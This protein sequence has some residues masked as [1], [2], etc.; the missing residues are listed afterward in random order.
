MQMSYFYSTILFFFFHSEH[1][2]CSE[3]GI[4]SS[5]IQIT[6]WNMSFQWVRKH[7]A[8]NIPHLVNNIGMSMC[9]LHLIGYL[10]AHFSVTFDR[11]KWQIYSRRSQKQP[12]Q[13]HCKIVQE[14]RMNLNAGQQQ[15]TMLLL[16][17]QTGRWSAVNTH[18]V[19]RQQEKYKETKN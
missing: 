18:C 19:V 3:S 8:R 5:C 17:G 11:D 4:L 12:D 16:R 9:T 14:Q 10:I 15:P 13:Q 1:L 7:P 2:R 6:Y